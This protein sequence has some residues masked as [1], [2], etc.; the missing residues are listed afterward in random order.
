MSRE[1]GL[2]I[3]KLLNVDTQDNILKMA[4]QLQNRNPYD[5]VV[6]FNSYSEKI[7]THGLPILHLNQSQLFD[8]SLLLF[9]LPSIILTS[10]FPNLTKRIFYAVDTPWALSPATPHYEWHSLYMQN[11]LDII[12]QN[13]HLYQIYD[14]CWKKPI[15]VSEDFSYEQIANFV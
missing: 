1:I 10:K 2:I 11:N 5:Q 7:D 4:K 3:T 15:G 14:I 6:I 13:D 9:D 12:T 8:G